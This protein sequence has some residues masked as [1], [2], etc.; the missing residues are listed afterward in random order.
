MYLSS[1]ENKTTQTKGWWALVNVHKS[2]WIFLMLKWHTKKF[3]KIHEKSLKFHKKF[4][5]IHEIPQCHFNIKNLHECSWNFMN[6]HE[7]FT[8]IIQSFIHFHEFSW[9]FMKIFALSMKCTEIL[10]R[11]WL[12]ELYTVLENCGCFV[13]GHLFVTLKLIS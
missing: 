6:F 1:K 4:T 2:S 12:I 13:C 8:K 7:K 11:P 3:T 10:L 5:K 9:R